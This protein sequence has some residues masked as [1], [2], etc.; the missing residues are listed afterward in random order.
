MKLQQ[1]EQEGER[2]GEGRE[3]TGA[4]CAEPYW[5]GHGEEFDEQ[6]RE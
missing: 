6:T 4:G 1:S 5:P 2:R 3:G